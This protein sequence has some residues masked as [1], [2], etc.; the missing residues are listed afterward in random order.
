ME[1][2][3]CSRLP[4]T[5]WLTV[6]LTVPKGAKFSVPSWEEIINNRTGSGG[7][8]YLFTSEQQV[9]GCIM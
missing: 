4:H 2:V 3:V 8:D 5:R 6:G 9:Y 1:P 7:D